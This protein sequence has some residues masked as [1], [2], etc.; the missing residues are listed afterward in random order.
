MHGGLPPEAGGRLNRSKQKGTAFESLIRDYLQEEWSEIVERMPLSGGEDRGDIANFRI[1]AN[2]QHKLAVELKN[3]K[4]M[5]L[6]AWIAE[7]HDEARH[8]DAVAGIV[9]HK[10]RGKGQAGEQYLTMTLSDF[11]TILHAAAS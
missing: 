3:C 8:Y 11:L 7:A 2:S 4:T 5:S 10:R 6:G 1:G 9:C